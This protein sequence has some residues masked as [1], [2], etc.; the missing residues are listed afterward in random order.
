VS[1]APEWNEP[2]AWLGTLTTLLRNGAITPGS[3]AE[4]RDDGRVLL[5]DVRRALALIGV[6][7][8]AVHR[9]GPYVVDVEL[10]HAWPGWDVAEPLRRALPRCQ[11]RQVGGSV[12]VRRGP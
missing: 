1:P 12:T 7:P 3:V 9:R 10:P 4:V 5:S 11:V 2:R 8:A 6:A